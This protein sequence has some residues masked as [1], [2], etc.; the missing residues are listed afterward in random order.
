MIS[1]GAG[2]FTSGFALLRS[3]TSFG[4]VYG[5]WNASENAFAGVRF[6]I[7]GA[8]HFAWIRLHVGDTDGI[9]SSLTAIDWAYESEAGQGIKAGEIPE[10]STLALL[11][12]GAAGL[13]AWRRRRASQ[14]S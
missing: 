4:G 10:P 1:A 8:D 7:G 9:P 13:L 12:T 3:V 2:N 6:Q 14:A 11:A 5:R